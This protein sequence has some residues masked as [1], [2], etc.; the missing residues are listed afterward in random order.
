MATLKSWLLLSLIL[1]IGATSGWMLAHYQQNIL[2]LQTSSDFSSPKLI[3]NFQLQSSN[4][5]T[6]S[7]QNLIGHW[8]LIFFGFRQCPSVCTK[9]LEQVNSALRDWP[10]SQAKPQALF[11]DLDPKHDSTQ[12]IKT[13]IFNTAP[14][15]I[16]LNGSGQQ[17]STL[18]KQLGI[19]SVAQR[20][21]QEWSGTGKSSDIIV[22]NPQGQWQAIIHQPHYP[23]QIQ[24]DLKL[25]MA[26]HA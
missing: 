2:H 16:P 6:Y 15:L 3:N 26:K 23:A 18:S 13:Y 21:K 11:V 8:S 9:T 24:H 22:I 19:N 14:S 1:L 4:N 12:E 20:I 10:K 25:M 5:T 17:I 7:K